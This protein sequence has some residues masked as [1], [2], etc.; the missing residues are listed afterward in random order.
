MV[1]EVPIWKLKTITGGPCLI[2][3]WL[4]TRLGIVFFCDRDLYCILK[5]SFNRGPKIGNWEKTGLGLTTLSSKYSVYIT[6]SFNVFF[7]FD[8]KFYDK[9]RRNPINFTFPLS[10]RNKISLKLILVKLKDI[11]LALRYG[12][13]RSD[14]PWNVFLLLNEDLL[15]FIQRFKCSFWKKSF[16]TLQRLAIARYFVRFCLAFS[17]SQIASLKC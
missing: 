3:T 1:L 7:M 2:A 17:I 15:H 16:Q 11:S 14:I 13:I 10:W 8:M 9:K 12:L 6:I 5:R 4:Q